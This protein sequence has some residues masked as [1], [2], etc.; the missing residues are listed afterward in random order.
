MERVLESILEYA[1][2]NA[3]INEIDD[4]LLRQILLSRYV[5]GL[6]WDQIAAR[7]GGD[8]TAGSVRKIAER[9]L[10]TLPQGT[11]EKT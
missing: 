9:Y 11:A 1:K 6:Q 2:L 8:N 5:D 7:I 4:P 3:F 10:K